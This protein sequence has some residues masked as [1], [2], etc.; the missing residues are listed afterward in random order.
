[1]ANK[2]YR[3]HY[4]S[5]SKTYPSVIALKFFLGNNPELN[6]KRSEL[7]DKKICEIGFGDGRDLQLFLDLQMDVHGVEPDSTVVEHTQLK[8]P[9]SKL[10]SGTNV[11]TGFEN[12]TFD[13]VYASASIYYLPSEKF[14]IHDALKEA[15]RILKPKGLLCAT[16]ARADSHVTRGAEVVDKN[17]LILDDPFYGFRKGQRYHVYNNR[18]EIETDLLANGFKVLFIGDYDVDWF[19]T[20]ETLFIVHASK[21]LDN[22]NAS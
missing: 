9:N 17:T 19:G 18:A 5:I 14:T 6:V 8:T 16:F 1:M 11:S 7:I 22:G 15:S 3:D 12:A 13:Y 4:L 20:R 21:Q 2:P 10:R